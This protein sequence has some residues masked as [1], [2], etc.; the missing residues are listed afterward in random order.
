MQ[1][2][3]II[4]LHRYNLVPEDGLISIRADK[5]RRLKLTGVAEQATTIFMTDREERRGILVGKVDGAF[6][7]DVAVAA[8]TLLRFERPEGSQVVFTELARDQSVTI[9]ADKFTSEVPA[10][11][12]ETEF[13]KMMNMLRTNERR[14]L[15]MEMER[16]RQAEVSAARAQS[17]NDADEVI[18][19]AHGELPADQG[20]DSEQQVPEP[21]V[22]ADGQAAAE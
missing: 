10:T 11:K 16:K 15:L 5:Y 7:L 18:E 13:D 2:F 21:V 9:E 20:Q 3:K 12:P 1:R 19:D 6:E 22:P 14:R 8:E 17:I 4:D